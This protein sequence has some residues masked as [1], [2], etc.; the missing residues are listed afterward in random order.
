MSYVCVCVTCTFVYNI[1]IYIRFAYMHACMYVSMYA[2]V[3]I[4]RCVLTRARSHACGRASVAAFGLLKQIQ[5]VSSPVT[6]L[7]IR[8]D[9]VSRP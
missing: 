8:Q 6:Y 4:S 7:Y 5:L 2:Y 1:R 3:G 9:G